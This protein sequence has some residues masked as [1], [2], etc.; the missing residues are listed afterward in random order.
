YISRTKATTHFKKESWKIRR[1]KREPGAS[2][3][4]RK[5]ARHWVGLDARTKRK[6]DQRRKNYFLSFSRLWGSLSPNFFRV[7]QKLPHHLINCSNWT[8]RV[9]IL[10]EFFQCR[11]DHFDSRKIFINRGT[12]GS[13]K[14]SLTSPDNS[15]VFI[16][17][18]TYLS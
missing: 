1:C 18:L 10:S 9:L 14:K 4:V 17:Q 11:I 16:A 13:K 5:D 7:S 12:C 8:S 6:S 3:E 2:T 15:N